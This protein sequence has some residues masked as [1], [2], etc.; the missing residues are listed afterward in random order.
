MWKIL[1]VD[2]DFINRKLLIEILRGRAECDVAVNGVE[3]IEAYNIAV[4]HN[5]R[6][7]LMLLDIA[8]PQMDGLE[9][10]KL[11]RENERRAGVQPDR[12]IPIVVVTAHK[13]PF[14]DSFKSGCD[15]Y[16]LKPVVAAELVGKISALIEKRSGGKPA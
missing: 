6:Y 12:G 14:A 5:T 1:V 8:M 9:V 11:I 16:V 13:K 3:A 7:D 10:M 2:D 15:D 4:K